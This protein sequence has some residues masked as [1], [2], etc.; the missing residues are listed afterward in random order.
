MMVKTK[1]NIYIDT[2]VVSVFFNLVNSETLYLQKHLYNNI[3]LDFFFYRVYNIFK[4]KKRC[5]LIN[6]LI[7]SHIVL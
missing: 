4:K 1:K 7:L 2:D 6:C 3:I 5:R